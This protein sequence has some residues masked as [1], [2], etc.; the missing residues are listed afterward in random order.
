MELRTVDQ[1]D[2]AG[3]RVLVRN[4]FNVPLEDGKV[5]DDLRVRAAIPTLRWLL[6]H[7][8]RVICCSHLGRPKGKRDPKYSLEPVRPVLAERLGTEVGFVDDVAG[9][10]A[11]QAA[12]GLGDG[13]VLL[14]QNLRYEPGEEKNDPELADRLAA[15]AEVYVDDAFGAAH[16]AHASVVGVAERLPAYAGYLLAGEVKVLSRLLEDPERPFTA[17]LGGSKV[18]DKLEVLDNLLG[19]VDSLVV[20]GGMCFTFLAAQGHEIGDSLFEPDQVDAVGAAGDG[21]ARGQAGAA[22]HRRGRGPRGQRGRRGPHR[23][24]PT[25]SRPAGRAWTSARRPPWRSPPPWPTPAPCSGTGP[26]ACSSW[27][28]SPPAPRRSPRRWPP[29]TATRWSAGATRPPPWPSSAWPTGSTTCPPAAGPASSCSRAR[30]C[31]ASPPSRP[32]EGGPAVA[33]RPLI[34]GNWKMHKNHLE[35]V[36]LTQKLA[37]AL[38]S[39]DTDAVEVA[40]CPPF[41]ALRSVGTLIDGD[42]LPIA[43]GAQD[44]HP[45]PQGAYTGEISAPMLAKLGVQYVIVGHSE[46]RQYSGEDDELVNRKARAVLE[47]GMRPIVCVGE[48]LEEREAG[49]T[50]E[51]VQGQVRGSLAG[52]GGDQVAGLVVAYEPVWA[53][54]TGRAATAD[55]AQETIAVIRATVADLVGQA[56]ADELR[57]QYGGSVKSSNAEELATKPDVDGALVGGASLDADEFAL[58]IKGSARRAR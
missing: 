45:E 15:L 47:A 5:T 24:P 51:V 4:D 38:S 26:W 22:A 2:V 9:D 8:A 46:R 17:V 3:R 34:A 39:E 30:P 40:V 37:W 14:L 58:I 50:A 1:A 23:A 11:S 10:Q 6:D 33:R 43:L 27:P 36:Q 29:P 12:E 53:I 35:G 19:R 20:G 13:Q 18:S 44:C 52:L 56:A 42:K 28:R 32:S 57:I 21:R 31:P 41:T 54:G 25:G 7:G 16:R 49:R 48:V 55:D